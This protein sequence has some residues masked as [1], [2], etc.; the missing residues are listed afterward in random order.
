MFHAVSGKKAFF[1]KG[2]LQ[3]ILFIFHCKAFY[4]NES[5]TKHSIET[6]VLWFR[7]K[8]QYFKYLLV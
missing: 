7:I 3:I 2:Q 4:N 1:N 5:Q 8:W 6:F